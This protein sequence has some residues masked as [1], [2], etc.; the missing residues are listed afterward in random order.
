MFLNLF[1]WLFQYNK[2]N[3]DVNLVIERVLNALS[4]VDK[5]R[6]DKKKR[7]LPVQV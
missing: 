5:V 7:I 2:Y 4:Q 1:Y 3:K 6:L